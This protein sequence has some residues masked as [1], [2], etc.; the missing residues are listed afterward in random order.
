MRDYVRIFTTCYFDNALEPGAPR[1]LYFA[2]SPDDAAMVIDGL[3]PT[4]TDLQLEFNDWR[5]F[6]RNWHAIRSEMN[7]F[8]WNFA[9]FS[10]FK[11]GTQQLYAP[12][13]GQ[14]DVFTATPRGLGYNSTE[15]KI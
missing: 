1:F 9:N 14:V 12:K 10:L 11:Q 7:S 3:R 8:Y 5:W 2:L 4:M 13:T 15:E 6:G